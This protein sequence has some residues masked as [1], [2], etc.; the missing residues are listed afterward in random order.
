MPQTIALKF[1]ENEFPKTYDPAGVGELHVNDFVVA[2]REGAEDVGFVAA[3]EWVSTEQLRLRR[4]PL[5]P[6]LR[7]ATDQEKENFF[8]RKVQERKALTLCKTLAEDMKLPM[9]VF[10]AR[11]VPADG[12]TV[13][14]FTSE[15][16]V[17]FR[18]L[19]RELSLRLRARVEL[20]QTGVRDEARAVD[21]Y[22]I[23]GLRTCCSSWIEEF[24][25]I[26]IRMAKV[27][28]INLPPVKLSGQ[29]GRLLCCLSYEVDQYREMSKE[30]LPKGA[31]VCFEG[32]NGVIVD[33]NIIKQTYIVQFPE[34]AVQ[35]VKAAELG[36]VRVPDQMK[37]MP[38]AVRARVE[39]PVTEEPEGEMETTREG[40]ES[41]GITGESRLPAAEEAG[42]VGPPKEVRAGRRRRRKAPRGGGRKADASA[43][44]PPD[45]NHKDAAPRGERPPRE[46]RASRTESQAEAESHGRRRRRRRRGGGGGQR[47]ASPG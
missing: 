11:I 28:D 15:Q 21:G 4:T 44:R 31:T 16:R 2:E 45:S 35:E 22:G 26:S 42:R 24:T 29:C 27:Q 33:R 1:A 30:L 20:W 6:L 38:P 47:P 9:K 34:G 43:D 32:R 39:E 5:K 13:I 19:V 46:P 3:V 23:C 12:R 8:V 10:H 25:P 18:Q 36:Q 7:R 41:A 40:V 17:D 14:T 37:Q